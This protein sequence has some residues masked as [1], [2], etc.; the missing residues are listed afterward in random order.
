M[1]PLRDA[2]DVVDYVANGSF[3]SL[4]ANVVYRSTPEFAIL[5]R[6][7][8]FKSGWKGERV[9]VNEHSYRFLRKSSLKPGDVLVANVGANAGT[10]FRVPDVGRPMT[11]G[12]NAVA[13][14]PRDL[15]NLDRRFLYYYLCGP[16]G[17]QAIQSI[18]AGSAQPKFN[19]TDLRRLPVPMPPMS[20]QKRIADT[21]SAIDAK[22]ELNRHT[23][24]T[25]ESSRAPSSSRG[26]ST[27]TL[28]ARR[29]REWPGA[30]WGSHRSR[31]G[32]SPFLK[33]LRY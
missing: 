32:K 10:V 3:A 26:S 6:L 14:K 11:L 33:R 31:G 19:K 7:V 18:I 15:N 13:L 21:L 23:N 16:A 2:V 5:V 8:D 28:F 29:W 4:K 22:I 12:P 17:Q 30:S 24:R 20:V 1:V 27:S 25:L 9:Y